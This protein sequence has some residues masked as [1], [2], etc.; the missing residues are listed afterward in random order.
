[1]NGCMPDRRQ[2]EVSYIYYVGL[3]L[4]QYSEHF[5]CHDLVSKSNF[6]MISDS[7]TRTAS[8]KPCAFREPVCVLENCQW[9]GVPCFAAAATEVDEYLPQIPR[10]DNTLNITR[11]A[12]Y[13]IAS[14]RP[15]QKTQFYCWNVYT[16]HYIATVAAL[17]AYKTSHVI[18]RQRIHWCAVCCPAT[19]NKHSYFYCCVRFDVFTESL[20]SKDLAIHVTM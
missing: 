12:L 11:V 7:H 16:N 10:R 3:R 2:V 13:S 20:P 15:T 8:G 9:C 5:H 1:M 14:A 17:T 4:I 6:R 18:P 19:S